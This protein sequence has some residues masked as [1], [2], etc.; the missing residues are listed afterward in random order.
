MSAREPHAAIANANPLNVYTEEFADPRRS[1]STA[2]SLAASTKGQGFRANVGLQHVARRTL[3][4][5][6][7]MMTV[8]L[9]TASNFLASVCEP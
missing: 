4:I 2:H 1:T 6:L 3:G 5:F 7:L 8:F 9:W